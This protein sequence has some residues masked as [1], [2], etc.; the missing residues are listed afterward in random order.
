MAATIPLRPD[1]TE[2]INQSE[3]RRSVLTLA[4]PS[5]LEN[6]L[7]S[8]LGLVTIL[9]VAQLG[10]TAV[11]GVGASMQLQILFISAFFA[12]S[13]G[14]TVI[15]AHAFGA[16][17]IDTA[18]K[19]AKQSVGAGL[20]I[21]LLFTVIVAVFATQM[22]ELMGA[23]ADVVADGGRFLRL[24][25]ISYVFMAVMFIL[26]G[27]LRGIGDTRTPMLVTAG[28]NVLNVV[29]SYPLI[30]GTGF[31]PRL[32]IDGA[33]IGMVLSRLVGCLIMVF[34]LY[35]GWRGVSIAG[36]ADWRPDVAHLRQ[37]SAIGLPSMV[38]SV[39]RSGGQLLFIVIVF[40]LGTA[41]AASFQ[42]AQNVVFLSMFP[43]FGFAMAATALVGQSLGAKNIARA[44]AVSATATRACMVWMTGMGV[45][46]FVFAGPIMDI[47]ASGPDRQE[48]IDAGVGALRIIA[49]AQPI[50]AI[51]FVLA[52]SLRGAG[53]TRWP[54]YS[55][56]V[57][58]W[59]FRLPL[60]YVFAITLGLGLAG[61]FL[62][63][64]VDNLILS[65]MNY[66]RYR[67]G[68]WAHR[69]LYVPEPARPSGPVP[70]DPDV[71]R[72]AVIARR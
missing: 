13:M 32:E 65:V 44:K 45:I 4:W 40:M 28:I 25:A 18:G 11:A 66:W 41:V 3:I 67:K 64:A 16:G 62:A 2:E 21:S 60:A 38:E 46:F 70:A 22:M 33:A 42:I 57:A 71:E 26:G 69:K 20:A 47:G 52:G 5:I 12:L 14:T 58:M 35:R 31:L 9:M 37:L 50:Q 15:T 30:F 61:V 7:Q 51:G 36:M 23:D 39:L 27:V 63:M 55:T 1:A 56:A 68:D 8:A 48:I 49:V 72:E 59:I 54:M 6:L 10:S 19:I 17:R 34:L 29:V 43:G 24:S 53:D